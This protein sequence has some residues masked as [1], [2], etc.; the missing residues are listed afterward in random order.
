[1]V[2]QLLTYVG[3]ELLWQ[4]RTHKKIHEKP[5]ERGR[6]VNAYGKPDRKISFFFTPSLVNNHIFLPKFNKIKTGFYMALP[7]YLNYIVN[8]KRIA[9]FS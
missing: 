1:M 3:I 8:V 2:N 5:T 9:E 4:L 6:G 7:G